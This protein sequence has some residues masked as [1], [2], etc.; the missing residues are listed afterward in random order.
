MSG[1]GTRRK[2]GPPGPFVC[3]YRVWL[4]ERGYS[5]MAVVRSLTAL[6]HLGRWMDRESV[7]VEQLHSVLVGEFLVVYRGEQGRL[8]TAGVWPL[9]D[10]LRS[11][12]AVPPEPP[13]PAGPVDQSSASTATGCVKSAGWR[14]A[15]CERARVSLAGS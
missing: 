5:P 14:R 7:A 3:G 10:Y 4:S 13:A 1:T 12:G 15:P 8:P 9:L 6:G 2:P 11:I